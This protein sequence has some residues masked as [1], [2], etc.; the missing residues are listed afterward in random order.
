MLDSNQRP[1]P[2]KGDM[3]VLLLFAHVQKYLQHGIFLSLTRRGCSLL[4]AWVG[5][6]I[7]VSVYG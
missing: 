4:F 5:V 3:A 2:Y 1:H 6:L 7:G